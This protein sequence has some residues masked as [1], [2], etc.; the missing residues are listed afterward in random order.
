MSNQK[1]TRR[2]FLRIGLGSAAA[3]VLA[4]CAPTTP[5]AV[6]PTAVPPTRVPAAAPTAAQATTAATKLRFQGTLEFWDWTFD[7]RQKFMG[8]LIKD[9]QTANPGITLKYTT[10]AYADVGTKLMAAASAKNTPPFGNV[11]AYWR[12]DLQR[13]G[14]LMPYP[15]N[16]TDWSKRLSTPF[17]RDPNTGKIYTS[18]FGY[19]CDQVFYNKTILEKEGIKPEQIPTKWEDFLKLAQQLTKTDSSGKITQVGC[20]LNHYYSQEWLWTSMIYQQGGWLYN[21]DGNQALWNSEAGVRAL[22]IIKDWYRKLKID[23]NKALRSFEQ[24]GNEK[25]AMY[26]SQGYTAANIIN[27][28]PALKDRWSTTTTPTFTGRPDPAWGLVSPEEGFSVYTTA[29]P[30]EAEAAF[31]F[32]KYIFDAGE[33]ALDWTVLLQ[34]PPDRADLLDNPRLKSEDVGQVIQ[35]Q[36]KTIPWRVNYGERPQ[37]AEKFWRAMFDEVIVQDGDPKAAL[38]KATEGM[39]AVFKESKVKRIIMERQYKPPK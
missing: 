14:A 12:Y 7:P 11:H 8:Q 9:F 10:Q 22:Q 32:I 31:A 36:A 33:H 20:A 29:K 39:N 34:A 18:I 27:N 2:E 30:E 3:A 21:A 6:P 23:D 24:F 28:F 5:T 35:T 38:D 13:A 26:I 1:F 16:F 19:Y 37:E 15:D 25:A 4:S 17:N